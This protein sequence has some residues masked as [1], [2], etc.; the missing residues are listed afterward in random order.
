MTRTVWEAVKLNVWLAWVSS[1]KVIEVVVTAEDEVTTY[2]LSKVKRVAET[3][4]TN[5]PKNNITSI[6]TSFKAPLD[7][8][9]FSP[10]S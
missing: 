2:L 8:H 10:P 3:G 9:Y 5:A 7:L 1:C 6:G 4:V